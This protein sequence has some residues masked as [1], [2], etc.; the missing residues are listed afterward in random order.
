MAWWLNFSCCYLNPVFVLIIPPINNVLLVKIEA[1]DWYTI[2]HNLPVVQGGLL[3]P[4]IDQ[5]TSGNLGHLW[6][7]W[8]TYVDVYWHWISHFKESPIY[9]PNS[10]LW[11]PLFVEKNGAISGWNP[12]SRAAEIV[13]SGIPIRYPHRKKSLKTSWKI[14]MI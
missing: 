11:I 5:P 12:R 1:G 14:I 9:A 2:Y 3:H 7:S 13:P 6:N 8:L 4:F 10:L